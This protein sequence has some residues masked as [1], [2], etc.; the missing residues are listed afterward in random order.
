MAEPAPLPAAG[1]EWWHDLKPGQYFEVDYTDDEV[2]HERLAVWPVSL[3]RW[4]ARSPDNDVW[5]GIR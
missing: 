5:V 3:D 1:A 4:V 2:S